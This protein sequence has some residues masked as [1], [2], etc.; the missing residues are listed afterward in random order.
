MKN[1]KITF[2]ISSLAGGGAEGVCVTVASGLAEAGCDVT[3]VI[4]T[5]KDAAYLARLSKKVNLVVLDLPNARS[6]T[7]PIYNYLKT[8]KPT[9]VVVFNY[10]LSLILLLIKLFMRVNVKIISRNINSL[11]ENSKN[12]E[13]SFR[14]SVFS[15]LLMRIYKKSDH[16]VNQCEGMRT[17]L[18]S[19]FPELKN[20]TSV[21]YNPVNKTIE[22]YARN[23]DFTKVEKQNYLLC[24]GRLEK[25]KAFHYAIEAFAGVAYKYPGLRLKI[26]GQGSLEPSLKSL[27]ISLNVSERI[28]FE[29]FQGN[30]IPY[31]LY[32]KAT[33]LTSLY[34]GFPNVLIESITL[35][36]PVVAVNCKSG[37]SEIIKSGCN[38][39]IADYMSSTSLIEKIDLLLQVEMKPYDVHITSKVYSTN[40][41]IKKWLEI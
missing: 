14:T 21:I 28:D 8:H 30:V 10:E 26:I 24:V 36:T 29:G 40:C 13:K 12:V 15:F 18:L 11:S 31:Y 4:L 2:F 39:F 20:K 3:L 17:D 5:L 41:I 16:I 27:A 22:N 38:G 37:P 1:K 7:L 6:S 25:Q 9:K 33:I 34:E 35:G 32:A 19:V 23:V